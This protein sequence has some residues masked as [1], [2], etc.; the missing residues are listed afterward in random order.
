M[1]EK[2]L[3]KAAELIDLDFFQDATT[4]RLLGVITALGGE[5]YLLKAMINRLTI[6][7]EQQGILNVDALSH[8]A[9]SDAHQTWQAE[10]EKTFAAEIL[11]P[12]LEPDAA[13][14]VRGFMDME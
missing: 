5:V 13:P 1:S 2:S 9:S 6:A 4:Q 3:P 12:W 10:E 8:A 11:R 14:D 7:L